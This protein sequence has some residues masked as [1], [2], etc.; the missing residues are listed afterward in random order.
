MPSG[1]IESSWFDGDLWSLTLEK[2]SLHD[3]WRTSTVKP[4]LI[5][6]SRDLDRVRKVSQV[7][8]SQQ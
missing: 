3:R 8:P 5:D 2:T 4:N 1:Q 7:S 6:R